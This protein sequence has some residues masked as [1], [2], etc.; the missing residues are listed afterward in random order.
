[1]IF[2]VSLEQGVALWDV[3]RLIP[4]VI[5]RYLNLRLLLKRGK[6]RDQTISEIL[7]YDWTFFALFYCSKDGPTGIP[8][9]F[10][11]NKRA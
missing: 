6:V 9:F 8:V 11:T 10:S 5:I 2:N 3:V 4:G 7:L 1:M